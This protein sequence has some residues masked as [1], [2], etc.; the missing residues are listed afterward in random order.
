[1]RK[2]GPTLAI[3]SGVFTI[4][5][6]ILGIL[7]ATGDI[8]ST[9]FIAGATKQ[10]R[11]NVNSDIT[12]KTLYYI[13]IGVASL[14]VIMGLFALSNSKGFAAFILL[15]LF[16]ASFGLGL[17]VGLKHN[18]FPTATIVTLSVTGAATLGLGIGFIAPK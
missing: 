11:D 6:S 2:I 18:S 4:V 8:T 3:V 14:M 1:M 9:E 13:S 12:I 10:T 5:M 15:A 7:V 17:W 16:A